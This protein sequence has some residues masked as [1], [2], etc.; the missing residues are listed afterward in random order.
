MYLFSNYLV[1]RTDVT[2]DVIYAVVE[3]LWNNYEE[4]AAI[5]PMLVQ[6]KP[7][8]FID[9]NAIVPYHDG[10]VRFYK[11]KGVWTDAMEARQQE[12]LAMG[13]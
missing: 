2:D 13:K 6:W 3:A 10:A 5:H 4:L 12:L 7:E 11:E 9:E 1:S 8:R